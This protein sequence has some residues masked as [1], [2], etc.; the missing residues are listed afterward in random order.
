MKQWLTIS[1]RRFEWGFRHFLADTR[2]A[3]AVIFTIMLVPL[4]LASAFAVEF[5]II[6]NHKRQIQS[7]LDAATLAATNLTVE[8]DE[9]REIADAAFFANLG[10][11]GE[12]H[13]DNE[14]RI[15]TKEDDEFG[16]IMVLTYDA[17]IDSAYGS[18]FGFLKDQKWHLVEQSTANQAN[19]PLEISLV[20][21]ISSSMNFD[22]KLSALK[23]AASEFVDIILKTDNQREV[24]RI[25]IVPYG[26][27]VYFD[28]AWQKFLKPDPDVA[29]DDR[30]CLDHINEINGQFEPMDIWNDEV[31]EEG[32]MSRVPNKFCPNNK[33]NSVTVLHNDPEELKLK[34]GRMKIG[35]GT[36][37][38]IGA[39]YGFKLLSSEWQDL[40]PGLPEGVDNSG[41][42]RD[43]ED[44][45]VK[46]VMVFMTDGDLSPQ[47]RQLTFESW[48]RAEEFAEE[49]GSEAESESSNHRWRKII[50]EE[51][52]Q[53][54]FSLVCS[55][56][57]EKNI[58]IYTISLG[59]NSKGNTSEEEATELL[60]NC[61]TSP[62]HYFSV[63]TE[64]LVEVF[65]NIAYNI[66]SL[67]LTN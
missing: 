40:I 54:Q 55:F 62:G 63:E 64:G 57:K 3:T 6:T 8:S 52:A 12:K 7:A 66:Q 50:T 49:Y 36:G 5:N 23:D 46:K 16:R 19:V 9:L 13:I 67:A 39:A 29:T 61:A 45:H 31:L 42:P 51:Q 44:K 41:L 18:L 25:N 22:D 34:L 65:E 4:M 35:N 47:R 43:N 11:L 53:E 48:D 26:T 1:E 59:H 17:K 38:D 10:D 20:L 14:L 30:V 28:P 21:D 56:A 27:T 60:T 2:G 15:E 32:S 33:N 58:I 37:G 24:N